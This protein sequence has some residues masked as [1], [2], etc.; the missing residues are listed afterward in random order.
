M[1]FSYP[2]PAVLLPGMDGTGDLLTS[3]AARLAAHRPVDIIAYPAGQP[4]GYAA[5]QTYIESRLP[6]G[7][8]VVIG[9]SF[10]GPLAIAVASLD[11]LVTDQDAAYV[12]EPCTVRRTVF[13]P[14]DGVSAVDF[15]ISRERSQALRAAGRAAGRAFLGTWD[16]ASYLTACR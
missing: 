8:F 12:E 7:R 13:V 4:L 14:T 5:L 2:I 16:E 15:G 1:T 6:A 10:S 9:E 3:F 11:V